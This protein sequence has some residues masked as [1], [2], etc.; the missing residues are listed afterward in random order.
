MPVWKTTPVSEQPSLTMDPWNIVGITDYQNSKMRH[1]LYGKAVENNE[2]RV[3]SYIKDYN[4][5]VSE[6]GASYGIVTTHSGRQYCLG[7]YGNDWD[8]SYTMAVAL[9]NIDPGFVQRFNSEEDAI[10]ALKLYQKEMTQ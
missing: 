10:A 2:G 1:I 5:H 9:A 7:R 3:T 6:A 8:G 4:E